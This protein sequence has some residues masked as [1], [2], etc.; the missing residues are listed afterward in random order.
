MTHLIFSE[1]PIS[2]LVA[3]VNVENDCSY[4]YL[5]VKESVGQKVTENS[6]KTFS[7]CWIKNHVFVDDI[8]SP[9]DDMQKGLQPK[10]PTKYCRHSDDLSHLEKDGLEIVW[11]EEGCT[12]GLYYKNELICVIP[13]WAVSNMPGYSKFSNTS[14]LSIYS[15]PLNEPDTN[16]M[17]ERMDRA[18]KFW[19]RDFEKVWTD[20]EDNCNAELEKKYGKCINYYAIDEGKFP[21]KRLAVFQKDQYKYVF[22]IGLGLFPQPMVELYIKEYKKYEKFELAFCYSTSLEFDELKA[23]SKI[24][25]IATIPWFYKTFL[26]HYHT[27]DFALKD[28]YSSAVLIAD[29]N[30][31]IADLSF[32]KQESVNIL[33]IVPVT[34][35]IYSKL[36]DESA[37]YKD[38]EQMIRSGTIS[39][40]KFEDN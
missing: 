10:I 30:V 36:T 7:A 39:L 5:Y 12:A 40:A 15:L 32:L 14:D 1:S 20:Y 11:G 29:R 19:Y 3:E 4:M 37:D 2:N 28:N 22:T 38:I 23:F 25:S 8:H 13:Y 18:K 34:D 26:D 33:W 17:F 6:L 9:K 16:A 21:P 24:S 27:V 35:D 31:N